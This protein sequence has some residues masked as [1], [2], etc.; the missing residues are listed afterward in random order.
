MSPLSKPR[1]ATISA[2]IAQLREQVR[3]AEERGQHDTAHHTMLARLLK[4]F[5]ETT[6]SKKENEN[7][8]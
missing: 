6:T 5:P 2:E 4:D 8:E 3:R 7:G 1:P